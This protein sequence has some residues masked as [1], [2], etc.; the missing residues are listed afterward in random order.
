MP[1]AKSGDSGQTALALLL[2]QK[3]WI[4][5]VPGK[6]CLDRL[7]ENFG[8]IALG[9]TPVDLREVDEAVASIGVQRA[10]YP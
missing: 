2:A 10:R 9:L 7:S 8:A 1:E 4:V 6:R 3:P 5:P